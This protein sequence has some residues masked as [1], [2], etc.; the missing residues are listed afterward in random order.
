M[1]FSLQRVAY[2]ISANSKPLLHTN[3]LYV[4]KQ[5]HDSTQYSDE[6][7]SHSVIVFH[8]FSFHDIGSI[9]CGEEQRSWKKIFNVC[10]I[11]YAS[12]RYRNRVQT[13]IVHVQMAELLVNQTVGSIVVLGQSVQSEGREMNFFPLSR[14]EKK[15]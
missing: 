12:T 14:K 2:F 4:V 3:W 7:G 9:M 8:H 5:Q 15:R 13:I 1:A 6:L 10:G 11:P